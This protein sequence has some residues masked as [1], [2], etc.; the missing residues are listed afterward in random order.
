MP[1]RRVWLGVGIA[2]VAASVIFAVSALSRAGHAER[3]ARAAVAAAGSHPAAPRELARVI[4]QGW[5]LLP[6]RAAFSDFALRGGQLVLAGAAGLEVRN[7]DGSLA[8]R[9][10]AGG[11]L[12]PAPLTRIAARTPEELWI[13]TRG[14]GVLLFDG[15]RIRQVL[16]PDP[17]QARVSALLPLASGRVL[18]GTDDAGVFAYD[19]AAWARFHDALA[20]LAVTDLAGDEG[21]LWIATRDR[22]LLRWRAGTLAAAG[23]EQGLPDKQ[24]LALAMRGAALYAGT[25]LGVAELRDGKVVRRIAEGRFAQ[26]LEASPESQSARLWIGT[27]EEGVV[28]A[29]LAAAGGRVRAPRSSMCAGCSVRRLRARE[30]GLLVLTDDRLLH[31]AGGRSAVLAAAPPGA[32]ADRNVSALAA[33]A[34]GR[35]WIGYFDRGLEI[36]EPGFTRTAHLEKEPVYCVNRIVATGAGAVVATA[37]GLALFDASGSLQR[38]LTRADGLIANHA[39]DVLAGPEGSLTIATPAGITF[40][41]RGGAASLYAFHG[42]VNNHVYALAAGGG[43]LVAGTL[44]GVSTIDEGRVTASYTTAN[45]SLGHNWITALARDGEEWVAGTYGAGVL[46]LDRDGRWRSS[47]DW[48]GRGEINPHALRVTPAAIYAGTLGQGLAIYRRATGRWT[49]WKDNLPSLS[50]TAIELSGGVLYLGTD[51]GL[52][53][54]PEAR[55]LA[56]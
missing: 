45:S 31:V 54:V 19:G 33:D 14:A 18:I 49:F 16:P 51:N 7:P 35:L 2:A 43:R 4:P 34:A 11:E 38:V 28:E 53:R 1:R 6:A 48:Q 12:P 15:R 42:L 3:E 10:R 44:G 25:P 39:T 8:A 27:L 5:D 26:A 23:P 47:P 17:A 41:G 37:N 32:L 9:Y 30:D 13:G 55:L 40:F 50:V 22:G 52:V 46:R 36:A 24:V 21:D 20:G 56:P 29:P